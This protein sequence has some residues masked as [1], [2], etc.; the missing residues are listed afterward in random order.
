MD[1]TAPAFSL[2]HPLYKA[3]IA[4]DLAVNVYMQGT[5]GSYRHLLLDNLNTIKAPHAFVNTLI[6]GDLTSLRWLEGPIDPLT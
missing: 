2:T 5:W 1:E 6:R 4:K 3:Q